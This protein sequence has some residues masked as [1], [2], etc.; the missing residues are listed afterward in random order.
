MI[1]LLQNATVYSPEA[2]GIMDILIADGKIAAMAPKIEGFAGL[3]AVEVIDLRGAITAPGFIDLHVHITGGGGEMGPPSKVPELQ[4]SQLTRCGITTVLGLYGTDGLTRGQEALVTKSRALTQEG[5][6]CLCLSGAYRYPSPTLTGD[7]AR[8]IVL[9]DPVVGVKLAL[10]D[11]RASNP[12]LEEVIRLA[13]DARL[14]GMLAGKAGI[15]VVHMGAAEAGMT[16]IFEALTGTDIPISTFLP[17]H[18]ERNE[19][20]WRQAADFARLGG[21]ADFTAEPDGAKGGTADIL[22]RLVKAGTDPRRLT[23]SSD[24]G[25]SLP[26]FNGDGGCIGMDVGTPE[27][28]LLE[29]G[30][31]VRDCGLPLE[32][33]LLFLTENP[34]RV[35]GLAGRKGCLAVGADADILVLGDDFAVRHLFA[36]GRRMVQDGQ[37]VVRGMF[38]R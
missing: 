37:A 35:L 33:A 7:V 6:T 11:H 14:G 32:T 17:T 5:I 30:R 38:E 36:K 10:A 20:L 4:L 27:T 29:L 13:S 18:C 15:V 16:R 19:T 31:L 25:G 12:S 34:A 9:V 3:P 24:S 28:L 1:K 21:T 2:L 26:R 22:A 23:L 8:D